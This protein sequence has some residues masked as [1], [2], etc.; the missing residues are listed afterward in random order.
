M[1]TAL[2]S[3]ENLPLNCLCILTVASAFKWRVN[4]SSCSLGLEVRL[5]TVNML[6]AERE[7]DKRLGN[8]SSWPV[9]KLA[10]VACNW[11]P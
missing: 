8:D 6:M 7:A 4:V 2:R 3:A 11:H 10:K 9:Q 1:Q 5:M